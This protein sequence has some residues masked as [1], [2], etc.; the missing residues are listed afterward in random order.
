MGEWPPGS[1]ALANATLAASLDGPEPLLR[2]DREALAR[3]MQHL[4]AE[5]DRAA[6]AVLAGAVRRTALLASP[7]DALAALDAAADVAGI[8]REQALRLAL[9]GVLRRTTPGL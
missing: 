9:I 3:G 1:D 6:A 8:E 2:R 7:S 4:L 5:R